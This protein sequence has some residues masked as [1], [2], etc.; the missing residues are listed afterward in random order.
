MDLTAE[1]RARVAQLI[2]SGQAEPA[3]DECVAMMQDN[4]AAQLL[5]RG[6]FGT[7]Q[8]NQLPHGVPRIRFVEPSAAVPVDAANIGGVVVA[9]NLI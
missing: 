7:L 8:L 6:G 2:A 3:I 1:Q 9:R 4:L 5:E